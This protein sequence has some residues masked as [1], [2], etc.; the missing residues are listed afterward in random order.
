MEN[1]R[2]KKIIEIIAKK[3]ISTQEELLKE[4]ENCGIETSQGTLSRDIA[5]IGLQKKR[6]SKGRLVYTIPEKEEAFSGIISSVL[7]TDSAG[8]IVVVHCKSG[9]ANAVC[10][11]IDSFNYPDIVG[12]IAGDDTIFILFRNFLQ[13]EKFKESFLKG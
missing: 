4:L 12:T 7:S 5:K 10:A 9:M 1:K 6:G 2:Q 11:E 3:E 8:N 13:A